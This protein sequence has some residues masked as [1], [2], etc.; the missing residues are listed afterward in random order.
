MIE[1]PILHLW[2]ESQESFSSRIDY[3]EIKNPGKIIFQ[4]ILRSE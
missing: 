1:N 4:G 2:N 3:V